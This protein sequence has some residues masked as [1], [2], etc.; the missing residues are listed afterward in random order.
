MK[1][2][3]SG[4]QQLQIQQQHSL[5]HFGEDQPI[6]DYECAKCSGKFPTKEFL[7]RHLMANKKKC[8]ICCK[9]FRHVSNLVNHERVH[10]GEKPFVCEVCRKAFAQVG[11]LRTHIRIHSGATPYACDVCRRKFSQIGNLT[12]HKLTHTD[13]KRFECDMCE[14]TYCQKYQLIRHQKKQH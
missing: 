14:N 9:Q 2:N 5:T 4:H 12:V 10:T 11:N 8:P 3:N 13:S 7:I 6:N 1:K